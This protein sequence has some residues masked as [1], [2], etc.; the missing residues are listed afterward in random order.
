MELIDQYYQRLCAKYNADGAP[1]PEDGVS[2]NFD[3]IDD[4]AWRCGMSVGH[5]LD[6]CAIRLARCFAAGELSFDFCD[7]V[8]NDL[9]GVCVHKRL[10]NFPIEF[11]QVYE[12]F[13]AGEFHRSADQSDD[14]I[15]EHTIPMIWKFLTKRQS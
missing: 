14:P 1:A 8:V 6:E 2:V 9:Y 13:D 11:W 4:W 5:F 15:A 12:A 7:A 3:L 10:M